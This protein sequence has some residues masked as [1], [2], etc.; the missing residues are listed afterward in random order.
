M[1]QAQGWRWPSLKPSLARARGYTPVGSPMKF[2]LPCLLALLAGQSAFA[3]RIA[4]A[5]FSGPGAGAVRDQLVS[6]LCDQAECVS[7]KK[8]TTA[9]GQAD[10]KKAKKEK[11]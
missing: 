8:V 3:Q 5:P 4:I 6:T 10:W 7:E 2:A 9:A 11:V 1:L